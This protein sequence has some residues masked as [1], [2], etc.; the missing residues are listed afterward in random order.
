MN[1]MEE[2]LWSYIDGSCPP[3]EHET[4]SALI[5]GDE[6]YRLKY[7][8][9]LELDKVLSA[10]DLDEPP[11]AFTYNVMEAIRSE[12]AQVPL[13]A[14]INKRIIKGIGVFFAVTLTALL[15]FIFANVRF[16]AGTAASVPVNLKM[17]AIDS[18]MT[19]TAME[20]FIFVD[21]I[22]ALFLA[23]AWLNKKRLARQ[24]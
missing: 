16:T 1:N 14:A 11:M 7:Q 5:A 2:L 9:L 19:R 12:E 24:A 23:D 18:K 20:A 22:M 6:T 4:I 10:A 8:E 15:V 3:A 21:V 17:P 13:K